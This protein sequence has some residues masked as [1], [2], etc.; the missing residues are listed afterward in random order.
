VKLLDVD[1]K[2]SIPGLEDARTQDFL[3]IR[4]PTVPMKTADEFVAIVRAAQSPALLPFKL[5][6][7]VGMKRGFQLVKAIVKGLRVP[8]TSLATTSYYGAL[9]IKYG[10]YA[11]QFGFFPPEAAVP[12]KGKDPMYIGKELAARLR[13]GA[14][15]YEM[16]VQFFE[17]EA[18]TPIEDP[19]VE[20]KTP[21]V[22]VAKLTIGKQDAASRRGQKVAALVEQMSF[23]PWHAR[24]DLRPLG[25]LM[26][27]RNHAYRVSTQGRS[28]IVEPTS[29]PTFDE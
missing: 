17:D 16:R 1:G 19:T 15:T 22:A 28:A 11:V 18:T 3:A 12:S 24:E 14:V 26:R 13:E 6:G 2:K 25:G 21:W 5:I 9:P 23:D 20:W 8:M 4:T 27:A 7:A 10:P 29:L